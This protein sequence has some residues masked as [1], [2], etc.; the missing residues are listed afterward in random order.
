MKSMT[1]TSDMTMDYCVP[2]AVLYHAIHI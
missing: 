2:F 1:S